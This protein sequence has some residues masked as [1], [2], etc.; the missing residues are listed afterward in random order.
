MVKDV[1]PYTDKYW[2]GEF[3]DQ[4]T[5]TL[6]YIL[7]GNDGYGDLENLY[8]SLLGPYNQQD[9]DN[10]IEDLQDRLDLGLAVMDILGGEELDQEVRDNLSDMEPHEGS[11]MV[12]YYKEVVTNA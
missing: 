11:S 8:L 3:T 1:K 9:L 10:L 6:G 7:A 12:Q 5:V 4:D 2:A